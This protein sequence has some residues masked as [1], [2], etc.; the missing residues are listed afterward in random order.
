VTGAAG[1]K[2][3]RTMKR[4]P[5]LALWLL[6]LSG[7]HGGGTSASLP[8]QPDARSPRAIW[9]L[10]W[11]FGDALRLNPGSP[12]ATGAKPVALFAARNETVSFQIGVRSPN[13]PLK[14]LT[15]AASA[16]TGPAG[17]SAIRTTLYREYFVDVPHA[18]PMYG[19]PKSL[20]AGVYPDGLIP[21]LD[22]QTGKPPKP[23]RLRA[24]PIALAPN[25]VQTY[26]VDVHVPPGTPP[27]DYSGK[28]VVRSNGGDSTVTFPLHVW[29]FTMPVAPALDSSFDVYMQ[30]SFDVDAFSTDAE[31]LAARIQPVPVAPPLEK[32]LQPLGLK[33]VQLGIWSG[34]Y[35]GHC[36]MKPP[37]SQAAIDALAKRNSIAYVVDQAADEIE[38]CPNLRSTLVPLV[39]LYARRFHA[40]GVLQLLTMAPIPALESDG[41]TTGKPAVD[42][43]SMLPNEYDANAA[44][45]EKVLALGQKAW[46]YTA[47]SQDGYSPKWE[48]D[49][50]PAGYRIPALVDES[51]GLTGELYWAVDYWTKRP[52]DDVEYDA[53]GGE[54]FAGEGILTYPGSDAGIA[55]L[56]PSMRLKWIRDGMYDADEVELL[57]ACGRGG[58]ALAQ[59]RAIAA[60]WH[61]W[62]EHSTAIDAVHLKLARE[63]DRGC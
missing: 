37:P 55:G 52:W 9:P 6:V 45:V 47:L 25:S 20:G 42:I 22:P 48:I 23:S 44:E 15:L 35:Y 30:P 17:A 28:I 12:G 63:L 40:A 19:R 34:A 62:T 41:G 8:P 24:G 3:T 46:F 36:H 13:F 18:S 49:A 39:R 53:G 26:W 10:V 51:L 7:C 54:Y 4:A 58:W 56:A 27:G 1:V 31:L 38:S 2:E 61:H 21:F 59:I 14:N 16:F 60:D 50:P 29:H 5:I 33:M 57:K 43:W 11:T 32:K